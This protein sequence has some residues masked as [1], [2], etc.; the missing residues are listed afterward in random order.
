MWLRV[1]K[2]AVR[3]S[4]VVVSG[5]AILTPPQPTIEADWLI[6]GVTGVSIDYDSYWTPAA[7]K[8]M[9]LILT[10]DRGQID[11]RK[12]YGL[13]LGLPRLDGELADVVLRRLSRRS[14]D[15]RI[16]CYNLGIAIEDVVTAAEIYKRAKQAGVGR[17]LP[18]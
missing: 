1:P 11:H 10:D 17:V 15:D 13:F 12:H 16:L 8:S 4:D 5:G 3:D 7:M 14:A 6:D 9:N 18:R 2:A